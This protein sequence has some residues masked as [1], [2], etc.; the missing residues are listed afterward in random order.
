MMKRKKRLVIAFLMTGLL[1]LWGGIYDFAIGIYGCVFAVILFGIMRQKKQLSVP[2]NW[3][4]YGL[5]LILAGYGISLFT[6][7]DKG[8]AFLGIL[9]ILMVVLFWILWNNL[10]FETR[11]DIWENVPD[12]AV[13]LTVIAISFYFVPGSKD[14]FFRAGRLGGVFQYSNTYALFLLIAIIIILYREDKRKKD[15]VEIGALVGGIVFCGSRSVMVLTALILGV[16]I[17]K[18]KT[19]RKQLLGVLGITLFLAAGMQ[20]ILKLDLQRLLK[21]TFTSSTLNGRFL[22]WQDAVSVIGKNPLGIGYMGYFFMQPRFQT[23]NYVTKFVHNDILQFG[24]DAGITS[25]IAIL[26]ILVGN[27]VNRNN[28]KRNRVILLVLMAHSLFDFD[29][30]YGAMLCL[31]MMCMDG[32]AGKKYAART[33]WHKLEL[34]VLAI[35]YTYFA[36]ALGF[37]FCG[38]NK[39][40]LYLYP[41]DTFAREERMQEDGEEAERIIKQNGMLASA[42]ECAVKTHIKKKQYREA[43]EDIVGMIEYAGYNAHYYNEAVYD[44]SFCLQYAVEDDDKEMLEQCIGKVKSIPGEIRQLKER[45]SALAY[46]INDRPEVEL[47]EEIQEYIERISEIQI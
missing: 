44:L 15:Y 22:Y 28:E 2:L 3:T 38:M 13:L 6:A 19:I 46:K 31:M 37:A 8:M 32:N 21:L 36:I 42:Y 40:A 23:G 33:G 35:G 24:L 27:I 26:I 1:C 41:F 16:W 14:Y 10:E 18:G 5:L 7:R 29:L 20:M 11:K 30:Q 4:T 12:L 17:I 43:Y 9:R 34:G 47:D 39:E 25:M 45:T